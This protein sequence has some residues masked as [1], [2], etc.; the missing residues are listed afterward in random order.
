M[1]FIYTKR[2]IST[3]MALV[4]D[5]IG[6]W[7][8]IK[9]EIVE[10]YALAY[11]TVFSSPKYQ[12]LRHVYIDAFAGPGIHISKTTKGQVRGSPQIALDIKPPFKEYYFID[13][14]G[15]KV[16]ALKRII[17][18]Y[19]KLNVHI[20]QDDCNSALLKQV[21][22]QVQHSD[23][24]RGLCLL[25]PYGLNLKWEVIETAGKMGTIEIFLNF[26]VMDMRRNVLLS[27]PKEATVENIKR[28]DA[29]WGDHSWNNIAYIQ[30][31]DLFGDIVDLK[32]KNIK[33][34]TSA[35]R[36]R[37]LEVAKFQY[38]PEPIPMRN[39]KRGILY[40]IFF[41]SNNKTGNKI[42]TEIFNKYRDR[43][44]K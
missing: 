5:E 35:F 20:I 2:I 10:K 13:T 8:E 1:Y 26:P 25:D 41:A 19:P 33:L 31:Q 21:F 24:K 27:N 28:M 43:G 22:P 37:L 36:E 44:M 18:N 7:S 3:K 16:N 40:F 6:Y 12:Y 11:S 38:V 39:T 4:L 17:S 29:F 30:M 15:D 42:L 34:V 14:D 23:Y 32:Q 9:H